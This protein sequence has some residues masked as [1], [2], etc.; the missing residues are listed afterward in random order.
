M[1]RVGD[2]A[3]TCT[4]AWGHLANDVLTLGRPEVGEVHEGGGG[5]SSTMPGKTNP[6]LS[7]LVRRAA[8]SAPQLAATLH[9]AGAEQV[10]QRADGA[11]HAEW[12]TLRTLLRRTVVAGSQVTDLL[13][14]LVVDP[15]RMAATLAGVR[16]Q[17]TA[18]QRTM[19]GLAGHEPSG[20]YLGEAGRLVDLITTHERR[21]IEDQP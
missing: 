9:L 20:Q 18:E 10:D 13:T 5:G 11:W 16:V 2:A 19:A 1:T 6:V 21:R 8:L 14:G 17:A 4:D 7:V 15:E 3:V 12:A